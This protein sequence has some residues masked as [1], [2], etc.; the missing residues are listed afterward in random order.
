V[1]SSGLFKGAKER[2]KLSGVCRKREK[3]QN[4]LKNGGKS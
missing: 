3:S 4:G 2:G 1:E